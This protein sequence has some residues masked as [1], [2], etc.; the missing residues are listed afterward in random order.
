MRELSGPMK[1][2]MTPSR[3]RGYVWAAL[4]VLSAALANLV[5]GGPLGWELFVGTLLSSGFLIFIWP[6]N[7]A[8]KAAEEHRQLEAPDE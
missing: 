2:R 3:R 7:P 1:N 8:L 6:S 5:W 4:T